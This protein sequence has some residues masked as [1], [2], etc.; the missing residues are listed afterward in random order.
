M[1][2]LR[3]ALGVSYPFLVFGALTLFPARAVALA[4]AVLLG[5]RAL[6]SRRFDRAQV[7]H[8][9]PAAVLVAGALAIAVVWNEGRMFL[10]A[11]AV[12]NLGLLV[13]FARTLGAGPSMVETFARWQGYEMSADKSRYCR[14]V[15]LVWCAFFVANIGAILWLALFASLAWWT[16]YTGLV[17]YILVGLVFAAEVLYRAWRFRDYRE[18]PVDLVLRRLFPPRDLAG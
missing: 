15:T 12:V 8:L 1:K 3:I 10:F 4:L 2:P 5:F 16:L 14:A 17:A 9:L 6:A 7:R 18:G 13:A 11:P